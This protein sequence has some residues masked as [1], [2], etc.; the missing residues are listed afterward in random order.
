MWE[1]YNRAALRASAGLPRHIVSYADL[2]DDPA[3]TVAAIHAALERHGGYGLR[4]P[5]TRELTAFLDHDLRHHRRE[6]KSLQAVATGS[7]LALYRRLIDGGPSESDAV[8][9][10]PAKCIDALRTYEA[11][12]DLDDRVRQ[13]RAGQDQRSQPNIELRLALTQLDLRHALSAGEQSDA[14]LRAVERKVEQFQ[15][16]ERDLAMQVA[17]RNE[18][19]REAGKAAEQARAARRDLQSRLSKRESEI[20]DLATNLAVRDE[21]IR[22]SGKAAEQAKVVRRDLG[23]RLSKRDADVRD[24]NARVGERDQHIREAQAARRQLVLHGVLNGLSRR[25]A[26]ARVEP[27]AE[28]SGLGEAIHRRVATYSTGMRARL[29][30]WTAIDLDP[31]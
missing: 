22:E 18:R 3:A 6:Q 16:T 24:L 17:V 2:L 27:V 26:Q 23:A 14:K 12:V 30:F 20:R 4:V 13:W 5:G 7:Q 21:R 10:V 9:A 28:L 29:C 8:D 25:E 19:I 11:T 15:R 31:I 1:R